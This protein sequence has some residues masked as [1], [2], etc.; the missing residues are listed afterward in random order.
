[1]QFKA[2][3]LTKSRRWLRMALLGP[4]GSG[5]TY[6]SMTIAKG[7]TDGPILVIDTERSSAQLYAEEL[8]A[9]GRIQVIDELPDFTPTTYTRCLEYCASIGVQCV[10]IDS[11]SHAWQGAKDEVD[12][13]AK[14][15]Q[16]GNSW[17]AW[18]EVTPQHNQLVETM[19]RYPGHIIACLR[20]KTEWVTEV[21]NG[22]TVPKK[23]GLQPEQKDG[24]EYE[25][26]FAGMMD[27]ENNFLVT[28]T[29]AS[30]FRGYMENRPGMSLAEKLRAWCESGLEE[31]S[32]TKITDPVKA[33]R[34]IFG[35][36]G[37]NTRASDEL[38]ELFKAK[39]EPDGRTYSQFVL[40]AYNSN[41]RGIDGLAAM[42]N[43][44][45]AK[46]DEA[47]KSSLSGEGSPPSEPSHPGT[48]AD[49]QENSQVMTPTASVA[50]A[51]QPTTPLG[52]S[53]SSPANFKLNKTQSSKF[54]AKCNE[55]GLDGSKVLQ[56]AWNNGARNFDQLLAFMEGQKQLV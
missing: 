23:V 46:V 29:R 47:G 45:P 27:E 11:L 50:S 17:A 19:L 34:L 21:V 41:C 26:D 37:S 31:D 36:D 33:W 39:A 10:I 40:H 18:R 4:T 54:V 53:T 28:K 20:V 32:T 52:Q 9:D 49:G 30:Q 51:L 35:N 8:N 15:S 7:L 55:E 12:R 22:K 43:A 56:E 13:V 16:S 25:F 6:T 24:I 42:I 48:S 1:M 3:T 2:K 5:K 14:K 44:L 38:K